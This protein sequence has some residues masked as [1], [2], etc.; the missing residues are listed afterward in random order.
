MYMLYVYIYLYLHL[1]IYIY[2]YIYLYICIYT[3]EYKNRHNR[4]VDCGETE[5]EG[6]D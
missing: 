4:M 1:Y 5:C 3:S 2:I 6:L